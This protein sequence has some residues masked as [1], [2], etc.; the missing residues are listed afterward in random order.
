MT[1]KKSLAMRNSVG[2]HD[3]LYVIKRSGWIFP[4]GLAVFL[5][6]IPFSTAGLPGDSIFNIEVTHEQMKFRLFHG[7]AAPAILGAALGLGLCAGMS[8]FSF[9]QDK[10]E[11]T[12][13]FS[14]GITRRRLFLNRAAAG[15]LL[16]FAGV[17]LPMLAS[18]GLNIQALGMYEGLVRNCL[19][20]TAGITVTALVSFFLAAAAG[21]AAGTRTETFLYWA[22][23]LSAPT[24]LSVGAGL[25]LEKLYWGNA[26]GVVD[27]SGTGSALPSL[28]ERFFAWQPLLFFRK[29][30][31]V[32]GQFVRPLSTAVPEPVS[33]SLLIGWLIF[34]VFLAAAAWLLLKKRKA[35]SA[36]VAGAGRILPELVIGLTGFLVFALSFAFLYDFQ[37]SLAIGLGAAAFAAVHLIWRKTFFTGN[38]GKRSLKSVL[39]QGVLIGA[40]CCLFA[41]GFFGSAERFLEKGEIS[42]AEVTY[43]GDP[44]F[45]YREASGS[46]TGRSYYIMSRLVFTEPDSIE[47]VKELQ[48]RFIEE[49]RLPMSAGEAAA[50]TVVPYDIC[51]SYTGNDGKEHVWYYDRASYRQLEQMLSLEEEP[52]AAAGQKALLTGNKETDTAW[53]GRAFENGEIYLTDAYFSSTYQLTLTEE[54][55]EELLQ[56]VASD[57]ERMSLE[58]RYFPEETARAVLM[59]TKNGEQDC[60]YYTYHLDNTFLY[61]TPDYEDTLAWLSEKQVLSLVEEKPEASCIYL[62]RLDPYIGINRPDYPMGMYFMAYCADT[63]NEFLIQKDFGNQYTI[64][65]E[66]EI[67]VLMDRLQDGYF[68]SRGGYLAA[69]KLAGDERFRYLFLPAERVPDFIRG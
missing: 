51:F 2:A 46:S 57:R 23:L 64:T 7:Q 69:V 13:F 32:H 40:V 35:E 54:Q 50:D 26:W 43:V 16:I 49:G 10:K 36:G 58:E 56:T 39:G 65:E 67:E 48:K 53:A 3:F 38:S 9:V 55:R 61:L 28:T 66:D 68:M 11:T 59:F 4:A 6:L 20:L 33:Y 18:L 30:M 22:G 1:G 45:L 41:G 25:L 52:E 5:L 63:D 42:S 27:Y 12:I 37:I 21:F 19:Y 47:K 24:V 8:L 34:L 14:L 62:Q 15:I 44:A 17:A 29:E 60:K 31:E